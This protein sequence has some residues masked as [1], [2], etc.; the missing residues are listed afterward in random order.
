MRIELQLMLHYKKYKL[1]INQQNIFKVFWLKED[2]IVRCER[3][4]RE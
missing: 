3:R 4:I 1:I 2:I